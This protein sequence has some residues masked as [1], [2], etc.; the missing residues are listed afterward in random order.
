MDFKWFVF[1]DLR[2]SNGRIAVHSFGIQRHRLQCLLFFLFGNR[3]IMVALLCI[4]RLLLWKTS[5]FKLP[6][7]LELMCQPGQ[8]SRDGEWCDTANR[9]VDLHDPCPIHGILNYISGF[10]MDGVWLLKTVVRFTLMWT[11][12]KKN[13]WNG[14]RKWNTLLVYT[15]LSISLFTSSEINKLRKLFGNLTFQFAFC[16]CKKNFDKLIDNISVLKHSIFFALSPSIRIWQCKLV[17]SQL[18][19]IDISVNNY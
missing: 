6:S 18:Q 19:C 5:L 10:R 1:L 12:V 8:H 4:I 14:M 11:S 3:A 15:I 9:Y 13:G 2:G 7:N 17:T 16:S